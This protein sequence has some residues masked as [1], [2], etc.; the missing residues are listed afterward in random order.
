[1]RYDAYT[2]TKADGKGKWW[3]GF[4]PQELY[5]GRNLV[6]PD[7]ITTI[8]AANDFHKANDGKWHEEIP[9]MNPEFARTWFLRCQDLLDTYKPDL[10]YF[11]DT[12]L[13]FEEYG[14]A[15]AAHFYNSSIRDKHHLDV[16][17]TGKGLRPDRV[18]AIT[19]DIERGKAQGILADPWQTD[20]CI[21]DWHYNLATFENHRYKTP[22]SVIH[23]PSWRRSPRGS[24]STARR[25]TARGPSRSSARGR[26]TSPTTPTSTSATSVL[27][28]RKTSA[29]RARATPFTRSDLSGRTTAS[30]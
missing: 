11:D 26:R 10:L 9:P 30:T 25:S 17:V 12:E 13:P 15:I 4:D 3:E 5:T 29:S 21:G 27:T 23:S 14:L 6:M 22:K 18:G 2:L 19:L 28:P 8:A 20:T 1:V 24:R 7:G 16:V